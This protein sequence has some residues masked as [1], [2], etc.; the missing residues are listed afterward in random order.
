MGISYF[1]FSLVLCQTR[2]T[3]PLFPK[4]QKL[5]STILNMYLNIYCLSNINIRD[6]FLSEKF[7]LK[8]STYLIL[9]WKIGSPVNGFE[10]WCQKNRH[11]PPPPSCGGLHKTHIDFVHG[12]I[13][14]HPQ[15]FQPQTS[16]P[17]FSTT[18]T[19][20]RTHCISRLKS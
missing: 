3:F 6:L 5:D 16:T 13:T 20:P 17:D 8:Y 12:C 15:N 11:R 14:F 9:W 2:N 7:I 19:P 10:S 1:W 18:D 4:A